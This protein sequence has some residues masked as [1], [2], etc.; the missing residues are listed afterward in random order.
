MHGKRCGHG[1]VWHLRWIGLLALAP[2]LLAATAPSQPA[3]EPPQPTA[4]TSTAEWVM[5]GCRA[6]VANDSKDEFR[7]GVC[8]GEVAGIAAGAEIAK[9]ACVP[10]GASNQQLV[11][12][13]MQFI[14][15]H[16]QRLQEPFSVLALEALGIVWPC[17]GP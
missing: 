7:Q 10:D 12:V 15:A 14:D 13:V 8:V 5:V 6:L 9:Q 4:K 17:I 16:S 3:A 1:A 2:V 11:T